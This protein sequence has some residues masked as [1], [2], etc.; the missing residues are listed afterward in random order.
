MDGSTG[1]LAKTDTGFLRWGW[2]LSA[3]AVLFPPFAIGGIVFGAIAVHRGNSAHGAG[4]IVVSVLGPFLLINLAS[5]TL[6][7]F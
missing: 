6:M 5:Q 3:A 4:M 7:P 1:A 2:L